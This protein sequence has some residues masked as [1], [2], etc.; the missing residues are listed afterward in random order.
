MKEPKVIHE[1]NHLLV[2]N[3]PTGWLV[4]GDKTGDRTLTDWA[5]AYIKRKYNKPGD[6]Y[7]HPCHRLDRPVGGILIFA[8]T[9]KALERMNKLFR[10]DRIQK[11]YLAIVKGKPES[12]EDTLIHYINKDSKKNTVRAFTRPKGDA[13][14]AEL[15]Y[16]VIAIGDSHSLL[17][18]KPKTGRPHQIRVQLAKIECPIK[19]DLRYG[20]PKAN[21][22]KSI[23][24][25]AF[26]II[27]T[28]PVKQEDM[29]LTCKPEWPDYGS[30][31]NE[32]D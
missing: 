17:R 30:F 12:M 21:P 24:L 28:H 6:V 19:G 15:S 11:V 10:E 27:F 29:K 32:L 4:Q 18:V 22:D 1:D 14:R 23:S 8:R 2:V 31:V 26:Q 25:H 9:S 16:D 20:Y 7:L 3:K 5:K 13:K